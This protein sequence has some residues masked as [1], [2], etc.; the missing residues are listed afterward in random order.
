[1]VASEVSVVKHEGL[2]NQSDL[3]HCA[4]LCHFRFY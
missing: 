3:L 2:L 4:V 1:M